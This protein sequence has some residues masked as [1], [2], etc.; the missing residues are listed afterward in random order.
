MGAGGEVNRSGSPHFA[1]ANTHFGAPSLVTLTLKSLS[2]PRGPMYLSSASSLLDEC[3]HGGV[4][5]FLSNVRLPRVST[6]AGA[7][8]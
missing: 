6:G 1:I 5:M 7:V 4:P 3:R 2:Q 8:V